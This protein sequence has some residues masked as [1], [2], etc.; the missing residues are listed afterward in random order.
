[1]VKYVIKL[2]QGIGQFEEPVELCIQSGTKPVVKPPRRVPHALKSRLE[3]KLR[4]LETHQ[5]I[6]KV[7]HPK[8]FV[9]NLVIIE[10]KDKSLRICL[11][12]KDLNKALV[13]NH[14]LIPTYEEIVS[15]LAN[16]TVFSVLDLSDGFYNIKL[17]KESSDLCTFCTPFGNYK[18]LRVPFEI[19]VAPEI[20]QRYSERA[21]GDIPGVIIYCDDLLIA[22]SS[23][24]E[25]DVIL[26]K[27]FERARK[28]NVKFN[29]N[30][31]HYKLREVRYFGHIFSKEGVKIDP[32][33]SL[34]NC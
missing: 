12:P 32:D 4:N 20:F 6:S 8:S 26:N 33:R 16:K 7:S 23:E 24:E 1:M 17:T 9:S 31:F 30:K 25:H 2:F 34:L 18:F 27:V 21:F 22:A 14:Y 11:D 5:I 29:K 13:K 28:C 3:E 15:K 19:S 10:K